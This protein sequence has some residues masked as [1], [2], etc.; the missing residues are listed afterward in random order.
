MSRTTLLTKGRVRLASD[1]VKNL[2]AN[3]DAL[4]RFGVRDEPNH[5]LVGV[6]HHDRRAHMM[7]VVLADLVAFQIRVGFHDRRIGPGMVLDR[8]VTGIVPLPYTL[9][10]DVAIGDRSQIAPV[11]G[12][13][14]DGNDGDVLDT[15]ERRYFR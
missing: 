7:I 5:A 8:A 4:D 15:H 3:P 1:N 11:F 13:V 9:G 6:D 2:G 12:I 14:D 10:D